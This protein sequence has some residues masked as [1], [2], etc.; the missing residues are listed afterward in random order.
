MRGFSPVLSI[1]APAEAGAYFAYRSQ[2]RDVMGPSLRWGD[3]TDRPSILHNQF[4][5]Q[6]R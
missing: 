2:L 3:V 1:V 4:G 6:A 5:P